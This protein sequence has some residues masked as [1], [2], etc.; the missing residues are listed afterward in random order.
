MPLEEPSGSSL[1][2]A[3]EEEEETVASKQTHILEQVIKEWAIHRANGHSV[4]CLSLLSLSRGKELF[5]RLQLA[6][7]SCD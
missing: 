3:A 5:P 4:Y 1:P 2:S 7:G 6:F